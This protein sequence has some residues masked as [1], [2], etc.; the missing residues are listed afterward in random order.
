MFPKV[1]LKIVGYEDNTSFSIY[2]KENQVLVGI[3]CNRNE[4]LDLFSFLVL[5]TKPFTQ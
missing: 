4:K 1:Q 5:G 3:K 2:K